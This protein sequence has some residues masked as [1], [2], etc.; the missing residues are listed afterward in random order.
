MKNDEE[1]AELVLD[2]LDLERHAMEYGIEAIALNAIRA[3]ET[4][5]ELIYC[6]DLVP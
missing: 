6:D 4:G 3:T 2:D 5:L 1:Y